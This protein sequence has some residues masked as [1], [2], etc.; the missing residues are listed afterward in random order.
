MVR[1]LPILLM[2]ASPFCAFSQQFTPFSPPVSI[3]Q[4]T[5]AH[6]W[7][8]GFNKPQF[9]IID[10]DGDGNDDLLVFDREG[11]AIIPF[12]K[13]GDNYVYAPQ[14]AALFPTLR[15]WVLLR[16]FDQD[17]KPD[18][19]TN[20]Y[21][22]APQGIAVYK[23]IET[24]GIPGFQRLQLPF[25]FNVLYARQSNGSL[26]NL[27][28]SF[29]D[30]PAIDDIDN[31]GDLDILAFEPNGIYTYWYRNRSVEEGYGADSLIYHMEDNCWAGYIEDNFTSGLTLATAPGECADGL[32]APQVGSRHAGSTL[33]T[34][35]IDSDG[36]RDVLIGDLA[37]PELVLLTNGG[38]PGND[39]MNGEEQGFPA[40]GVPV[41]IP[42][43]NAAF[44]ADVN[45]DGLDDLLVAPN[46]GGLA[47]DTDNTW[48]Y[49]N[50]GTAEDPVF[51][52]SEKDFL[53]GGMIDLGT[54]AHPAIADVNA[55]GLPD[56][57]VGNALLYKEGGVIDPRLFLF[58]N[59]GSPTEPAF[60]LVSDDWLGLSSFGDDNRY[61][62]APAFGDL[63]SD[64]DADL[65]IGENS[66][67]FIYLENIAG[68]GQPMEFA[69]PEFPYAGIDIINSPV[70]QIVD[71]NRDGLPDILAGSRFGFLHFFKNIGTP[72]TPQFE[73]DLAVDPN[74]FQLGGVDTRESAF[75]TRGFSAPAVVEFEGRYEIFCGSYRKGLLRFTDI[76]DNLA[77]TFKLLNSIEGV[78]HLGE[79]LHPAVADLDNDGLL[80]VVI[81]NRRGGL[82]LFSTDLTTSGTTAAITTLELP[83]IRVSPNP[84][85]TWL[86]LESSAAV[87]ENA[88]F[89]IFS[90]LGQEVTRHSPLTN[91]APIMLPTLPP[92]LYIWRLTDGARLV[93]VGKVM[94]L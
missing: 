12:V 36:D 94:I 51:T 24:N 39:W 74:I 71:L 75:T 32:V 83:D 19:F 8:G 72:G 56:I 31:D 42:I 57:V 46:S 79:R 29:E 25:D 64:G 37:N 85:S 47:K 17:G 48:L 50:T 20:A 22:Q 81:G 73:A 59:T 43:F 53:V 70:P 26:I 52:L 93:G 34:I 23:G 27:Y 63:D 76:D 80:E 11:G 87:P 15:D 6:P 40:S 68:A 61:D 49:L 84:A 62:F 78:H 54:G 38:S 89:Q 3:G 60:E 30:I 86:R 5:L 69:A 77:D 21:D 65:L 88:V 2:L 41:H 44:A 92:G 7:A 55:D 35:D 13:S 18:L 10:F 4:I 45:A 28:C 16:D 33:L 91:E 14:Y 67:R 90:P 1:L 9:S 58:Q 82:S 66:G